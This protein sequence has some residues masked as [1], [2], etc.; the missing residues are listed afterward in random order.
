MIDVERSSATAN[1]LE[2]KQRVFDRTIG[3]W[4]SKV[5]DLQVELEN[6]Q[7]ESRTC[8]AELYR[9]RAQWEDSV[10]MVESIKRE[11]KNLSGE[12]YTIFEML[13]VITI[14]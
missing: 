14:F 11:N 13:L 10:N 1:N 2:K 4:Q 8:S 12:L 6:A 7:K 3:E 5:R 9:T